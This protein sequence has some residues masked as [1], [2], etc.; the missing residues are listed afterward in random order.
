[1]GAY[2]DNYNFYLIDDANTIN[3]FALPGGQISIT[4]GLFNR[5]E[6]E[7]QLA[8]VLGHEIGHV[9]ERHGAEHMATAQLTQGLIGSVVAGTGDLSAAQVAS[10]VGQLVNLKYGRDDELESDR[11]GVRL[12]ADAGYD[13]RALIAVMRVLSEASGGAG[14]DFFAS[15]PNPTNRIGEIERLI[16]ERYPG[17][18][19]DDLEK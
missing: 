4:K 18:V 10:M 16:A 15:H 1:K 14:P 9:I 13:P 3:A 12:L 8:G 11:W 5:L 7:A 6:N 19:P 2:A 17:G